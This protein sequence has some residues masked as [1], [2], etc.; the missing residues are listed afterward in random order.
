MTVGLGV[1]FSPHLLVFVH[2]KRHQ[3]PSNLT[4]PLDQN[5]LLVVVE[6]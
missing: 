3:E 4:L 5:I 1:C 6:C 2:K